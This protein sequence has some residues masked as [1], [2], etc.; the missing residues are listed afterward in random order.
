[1]MFAVDNGIDVS[2]RGK[3]TG[4]FAA[5]GCQRCVHASHDRANSTVKLCN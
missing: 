2:D 5:V 4:A 1:M 3:Y